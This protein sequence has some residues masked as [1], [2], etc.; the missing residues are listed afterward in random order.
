M[1]PRSAYTKLLKVCGANMAA[2]QFRVVGDYS[3]EY[4]YTHTHTHVFARSTARHHLIFTPMNP[5]PG[6]ST[7][8][9]SV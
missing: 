4:I 3:P 7:F 8:T 5:A 6:G 1:H 9:R 2:G